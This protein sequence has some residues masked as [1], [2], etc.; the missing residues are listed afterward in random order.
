[1]PREHRCH[2]VNE[3]EVLLDGAVGRRFRATSCDER[4]E[5]HEELW[6]LGDPLFALPGNDRFT[7]HMARVLLMELHHYFLEAVGNHSRCSFRHHVPM[8]RGGWRA[9]EWDEGTH[10]TLDDFVPGDGYRFLPDSELLS[11]PWNAWSFDRG[12]SAW[13]GKERHAPH[14]GSLLSLRSQ[15]A[16]FRRDAGL[17]VVAS[18]EGAE[19]SGTQASGA[20]PAFGPF[21]L[22][23][24]SGPGEAPHLEWAEA[25]AARPAPGSPLRLSARV[26]DRPWIVSIEAMPGADRVAGRARSGHRSPPR[27][28]GGLGVSDL[29]LFSWDSAEQDE[30]RNL[31]EV[32]P[33]LLGTTRVEAHRPIGVFWEIYDAPDGAVDFALRVEPGQSGILRRTLGLLRLASLPAP[34]RVGWR[35]DEVAPELDGR[36]LR[37]DLGRLDPG[38][39]EIVLEVVASGSGLE[40]LEIRRRIEVVG[41]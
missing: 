32:F 10:R 35:D 27:G 34:V 18:T 17:L 6:W 26:E 29:A 31:A 2:W 5:I 14:W 21:A 28:A 12:L 9:W 30:Y 13:H 8:M 1:M 40:P 33:H 37:L 3:A 16:I 25:G 11:D 39:W 4:A 7:E 23:L 41:P 15:V 38:V 20:S 19:R 36:S 24:S 22:A